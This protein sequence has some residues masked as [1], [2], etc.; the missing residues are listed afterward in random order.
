MEPNF[1]QQGIYEK[2]CIS[3]QM[4]FFL[5][6]CVLPSFDHLKKVD[7]PHNI[8][9]E[10]EAD[11]AEVRTFTDPFNFLLNFLFLYQM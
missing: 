11:V 7:K 2:I 4:K 6:K 5:Y 9:R 1:D 8:S 10:T 3:N